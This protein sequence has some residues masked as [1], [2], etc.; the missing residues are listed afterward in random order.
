MT[1]LIAMAYTWEMISFRFSGDGHL[2]FTCMRTPKPC[3]QMSFRFICLHFDQ[4]KTS[5]VSVKKT[6]VK[7]DFL[8]LG[9]SIFFHTCEGQPT[10]NSFFVDESR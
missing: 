4:I 3:S 7:F 5:E 2:N 10:P 1:E 8:F 6:S 9:R